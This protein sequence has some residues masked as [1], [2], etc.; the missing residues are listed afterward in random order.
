MPSFLLKINFFIGIW[1]TILANFFH[2]HLCLNLLHWLLLLH[3]TVI[4]LNEEGAVL[5]H[6]LFPIR[7]Q[8]P[9]DLIQS[10]DV[11]HFQIF[12]STQTFSK[13]SR[14]VCLA[15]FPYFPLEVNRLSKRNM[16]E[17]KSL[18]SSPIALKPIPSQHFPTSVKSTNIHL[19]SQVMNLWVTF[20]FV[21]PHIQSLSKSWFFYPRETKTAPYFSTFSATTQVSATIFFCLDYRFHSCISQIHSILHNQNNSTPTAKT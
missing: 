20:Y 3:S 8:L 5:D 13:S 17:T 9:G 11:K 18:V 6:L 4:I 7:V 14:S 16:S 10:Q 12:I 2:W 1:D 15:V 19:L 21:F